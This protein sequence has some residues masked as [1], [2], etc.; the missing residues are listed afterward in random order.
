[1]ASSMQIE[2][3]RESS[4]KF[5]ED[6][7]SESFIGELRKLIRGSTRTCPIA[8]DALILVC[9]CC[10]NDW[11]IRVSERLDQAYNQSLVESSS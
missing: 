1:M 11:D 10:F 2:K 5:Q 6:E 9:E 7:E 3:E 8:T 4:I